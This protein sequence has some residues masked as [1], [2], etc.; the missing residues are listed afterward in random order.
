MV[1]EYPAPYSTTPKIFR[2]FPL[3][4]ASGDFAYGICSDLSSPHCV[5]DRGISGLKGGSSL[6]GSPP[7][8]LFESLAKVIGWGE[9]PYLGDWKTSPEKDFGLLLNTEQKEILRKLHTET[10]GNKGAR[11][12]KAKRFT[13]FYNLK[14]EGWRRYM[15]E[16]DEGGQS[17]LTRFTQDF[18]H[19]HQFPS[20]CEGKKFFVI[21]SFPNDEDFGLGAISQA[22]ATTLALAIRTDRIL[23]YDPM[24]SPGRHFIQSPD[25]NT[26]FSSCHQSFD[27]IFHRITNCTY[28]DAVLDPET[29]TYPWTK[30]VPEIFYKTHPNSLPPVLGQAHRERFPDMTPNAAKY[31]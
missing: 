8:S 5:T 29:V 20:S 17:P 15:N 28:S 7:L 23:I 18:I 11:A 2:S 9:D 30:P 12:E 26:E 4:G 21:C 10:V 13:K 6:V 22:I 24:D 3:R 1:L 19:K 14:T 31:W 16:L 27:C 25:P